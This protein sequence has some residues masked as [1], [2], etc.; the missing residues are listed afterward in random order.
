[1]GKYTPPVVEETT[2]AVAV[3]KEAEQ[4]APTIAGVMTAERDVSVTGIYKSGIDDLVKFLKHELSAGTPEV[5]GDYQAKVMD[6]MYN[7]C[8]LDPA[9]A[10]VVLDHLVVTIARNQ[11]VFNQNEVFAALYNVESQRK[12]PQAAIDRYKWFMTF[13]I[14]LAKNI[15]MRAQYVASHDIT[16]FLA[17]YP[18]KARQSLSQYIYR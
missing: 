13:F 11:A 16:K 6:N 2:S 3:Q 7:I 14:G 5:R 8:M 10:A 15:R 1:M 17:M 12:R 18:E 4:V 9:D